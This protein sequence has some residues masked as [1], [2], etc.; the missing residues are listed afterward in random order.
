LV[1]VLASAGFLK[2]SPARGVRRTPVALS[3]T[4]KVCR[5]PS[6]TRGNRPL[7]VSVEV[8]FGMYLLVVLVRV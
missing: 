7:E 1:S 2:I 8:F 6:S 5:K 3:A 4:V